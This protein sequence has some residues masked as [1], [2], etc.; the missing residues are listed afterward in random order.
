MG[1]P[2]FLIRPTRFQNQAGPIFFAVLSDATLWLQA[3]FYK[4][5]ALGALYSWELFDKKNNYRLLYSRRHFI[6]FRDMLYKK[7]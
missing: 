3:L 2:I 4:E 6:F 7:H 5:E 1:I